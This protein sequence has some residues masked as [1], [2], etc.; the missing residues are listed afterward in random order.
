MG[1]ER[2]DPKNWHIGFVSSIANIHTRNYLIP[3]VN[4]F[5]LKVIAGKIIKALATTTALIVGAVEI[6]I[7]K[8]MQKKILEQKRNA[9]NTKLALAFWL[10]SE[11]TPAIKAKDKP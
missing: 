5:K 11:P 7:I 1:F 4:N 3:E 10:F 9:K 6:A 2:D 8:G